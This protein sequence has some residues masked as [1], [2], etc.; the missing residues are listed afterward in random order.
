MT[1]NKLTILAVGGAFAAGAFG[2]AALG[3][4]E[5]QFERVPAVQMAD[6]ERDDRDERRD[7]DDRSDR[8]ID[9]VRDDLAADVDERDEEDDDG[10]SNNVP[11]TNSGGTNDGA[12]D[13]SGSAGNQPT[14][15]DSVAS[16]S[17]AQAPAPAPAPAPVYD[18]HSDDGG[19]Y[20]GGSDYGDS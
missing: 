13:R 9:G 6:D 11:D 2:T 1:T 20:G 8:R 14:G 15:D 19:Y 12:D 18:D 5:S 17:V 16:V 7:P 10:D 3:D 4:D